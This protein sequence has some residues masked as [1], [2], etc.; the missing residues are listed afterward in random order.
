MLGAFTVAG[1]MKVMIPYDKV[2]WLVR[3]LRKIS[4]YLAP[5]FEYTSLLVT[6]KTDLLTGNL[7][8]DGKVAMVA[9]GYHEG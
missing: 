8:T 4:P 7:Q 9:L 1:N 5:D 2:E 3:F 6:G